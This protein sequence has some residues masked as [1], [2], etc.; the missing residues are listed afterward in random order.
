MEAAGG[1]MVVVAVLD[2]VIVL[3]WAVMT[4]SM[5]S[6]FSATRLHARSIN[7]RGSLI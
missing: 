1:G 7:V 5:S 4:S 3:A 2:M 6:M